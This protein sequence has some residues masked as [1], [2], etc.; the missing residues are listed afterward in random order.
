MQC[1]ST[2]QLCKGLRVCSHQNQQLSTQT[3]YSSTTSCYGFPLKIHLHVL[4]LHRNTT[5]DKP[6]H[7]EHTVSAPRGPDTIPELLTEFSSSQASG[8]PSALADVLFS[9]FY[10][11]FFWGGG[12][13]KAEL[14]TC[15]MNTAAHPAAAGGT[16]VFVLEQM[17]TRVTEGFL[18]MCLVQKMNPFQEG[19]FFVFSLSCI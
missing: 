11:L 16:R 10:F 18:L 14:S 5:P 6:Q 12:S 13:N 3:P 9:F 2:Q 4:L 7:A 17:H 1:L 8:P 15:S 19:G